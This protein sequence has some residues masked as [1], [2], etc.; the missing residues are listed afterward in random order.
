MFPNDFRLYLN[1]FYFNI[2]RHGDYRNAKYWLRVYKHIHIY[3]Y[4]EVYMDGKLSICAM[5]TGDF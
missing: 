1:Q 4:L 5:A 3:I 2:E